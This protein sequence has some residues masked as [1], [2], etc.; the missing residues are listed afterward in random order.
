MHYVRPDLRLSIVRVIIGA[1]AMMSFVVVTLPG[2][3]S[4][5]F[6]LASIFRHGYP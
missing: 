6:L 4:E 2:S 3:D 5:R 1:V